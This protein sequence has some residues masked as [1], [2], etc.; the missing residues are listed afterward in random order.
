MGT[1]RG[2]CVIR[3]KLPTLR[4]TFKVTLTADAVAPDSWLLRRL[5]A[6]ARPRSA[7]CVWGTLYRTRGRTA[8]DPLFWRG[9]TMVPTL[10]LPEDCGVR[11]VMLKMLR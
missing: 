6:G 4:S 10:L 3:L 1:I 7:A 11:G 5:G 8:L 2:D 9:V